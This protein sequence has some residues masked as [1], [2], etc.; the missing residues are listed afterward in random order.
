MFDEMGYMA[1][2]FTTVFIAPIITVAVAAPVVMYIVARWRT[3]RDGGPPDPQIGLKVAISWFRLASYQL[4]LCGG[5]ML[6]YGIIGDLG[7]RGKEEVMRIAGGLMFPAAIIYAAHHVALGF[8]NASERPMVV[9]MFSGFN[10]IQTGIIGF[11]A[12]MLAGILLFQK[13]T[14]T[15]LNRMAWSLVLVYVPAWCGQGMFMARELL[16]TNMRSNMPP[17]VARFTNQSDDST[18]EQDPPADPPS[19]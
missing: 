17:A 14:P 15:Q 7:D 19:A 6:L 5:F 8:T 11:T 10:L 3:Y 9:R 18:P 13:N 12:L 4:L 2:S 16:G 1:M